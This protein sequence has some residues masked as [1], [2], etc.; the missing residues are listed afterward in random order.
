IVLDARIMLY[1]LTCAVVAT[2]LCGIIPAL[3]GSRRDTRGSLAQAGRTQ[4]SSRSAMQWTLVGAQVA[5]AVTLLAGAGLLLRS[6]Q[7]LGRVSPGFDMTHVLTLRISGSWAENDMR[8]RGKRTI[9]F[10]ETVPGIERAAI[11]ASFPG[12]P[13]EFPSEFTLLDGGA[14]TE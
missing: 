2:I 14:G 1:T 8:E 10:L 4:V 6:F 12:V 5:L 13:T 3:R 7:A 11:S 9:D